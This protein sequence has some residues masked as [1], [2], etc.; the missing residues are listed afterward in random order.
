MP[1]ANTWFHKSCNQLAF[2]TAGPTFALPWPPDGYDDV[3]CQSCKGRIGGWED[4]ELAQAVA[5]T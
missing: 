2:S 4:V 3:I 1:Q 5:A